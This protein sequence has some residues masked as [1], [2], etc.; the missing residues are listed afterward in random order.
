LKG[1]SAQVEKEGKVEEGLFEDFV[2]WGKSIINQKTDSNA[3]ANSRIDE[4]EAYIADLDSGRV[5][6]TSERSD[7]EAEIAGLMSDMESATAMRK[8]ENADFDEAKDEMTKAV[9]ALKSAIDTLGKAT[10]DHKDGV[11]LA[12]RA[13]LRG[14]SAKGGMA[15][16]VEKQA[17]LKQAAELGERFLSKSDATFLKRVLL[18]E[19]P[20][21]DWKK[22]NRKATFKMA[23]KARSFK[24]QDVLKKMHQTFT[25]NLKDAVDAEAASLASYDSLTSSKDGQLKAAQKALNKMASEGG[26]K[27]MSRQE[28]KDEADDLKKQV[29]ND[30]KFIKQTEKVLADKKASWKVRSELRTGELAAISKAISILFNDDSRDLFKKSFDSQ[31]FLQVSQKSHKVLAQKAVDAIKEAAKRSGDQRLLALATHLAPFKSV[32]GA[33]DP[34]ISAIDKMVKTLQKE[35]QQDLETKQTCESDRMENTRKAIVDSR[36]IDDKTDLIT[37]LTAQIAD[38]ESKIADLQAEHKKTTDAL[39]KATTMRSDETKAWKQTDTDDKH[40][41]ATVL[42]AKKALQAFYQKNNLGLVQKATQ[43]V[44]ESAGDAPP[45]PPPT[46]EGGYG[47]KTGESQGIVAIM[48]MVREDIIKDQADAKSDEDASQKE[49]DNFKKDSED[50]MKELKAEEDRTAKDMG[51]AQTKK[52][53]T[54]RQ[55]RTQKGNLDGMLKKISDIDPN[56]EYYM[57]NYPMRR[58]NRQIEIDGL[59]KAKS[60]LKGGKFD[61]GP[62]PNREMTVG[63][64]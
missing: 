18:G 50:K 43:P 63:D 17:A 31:F 62:D 6:L 57:V 5:E 36:E 46:W 52:G 7:L 26:A 40:A 24:I 34:I 29:Q 49:F 32:K 15:A 4:L 2:C 45:P 60:I 11:L 38:C 56:C 9:T 25:A 3:A 41:A 48:E 28:S 59:N 39:T 10:K 12:V 42:N 33:F 20:N 47:G 61:E 16:L 14:A 35:E 19:V 22:L 8:K 44:A 21:V 64:A 55:R 53:Q 54:E 30:E 27:G 13:G 37:K 23:Y 1:L 51:K 58:E